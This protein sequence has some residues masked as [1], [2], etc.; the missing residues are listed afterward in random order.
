[1][2][3][4]TV[5]YLLDTDICIYLLNGN[6]QIKKQVAQ[7][8]IETLAVATITKGELYFG[9][10][11]SSRVEANLKRIQNFF[12]TPGPKVL[13][14]DDEVMDYFG[15]FKA[16]LRSSGQIIGDID[17]LIASVAVSNHLTLVT[18][19]IRHFERISELSLENWL[20]DSTK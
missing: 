15:Q 11:N 18:N 14:L 13:P 16:E 9:A 6:Q 2:M 1:M 19:N 4:W 5:D 8:G 3:K 17:L 7:V 10:Y 12:M 20:T